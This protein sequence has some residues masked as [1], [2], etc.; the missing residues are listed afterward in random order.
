MHHPIKSLI[1]DVL[2]RIEDQ[3]IVQV[4]NLYLLY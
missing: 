1:N 2:V 3:T 4:K